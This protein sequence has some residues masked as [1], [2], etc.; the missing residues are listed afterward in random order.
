MLIRVRALT[1][2][3]VARHAS[4]SPR[5][6]IF[7]ALG[8]THVP[9]AMSAPFVSNH[10]SAST[11]LSKRMVLSLP[12]GP[13][14]LACQAVFFLPVRRDVYVRFWTWAITYLFLLVELASWTV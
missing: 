12:S 6:V 5:T 9:R 13:T 2:A 8:S 10:R 1:S 3:L 11:F 7:P 4:A 14:Y